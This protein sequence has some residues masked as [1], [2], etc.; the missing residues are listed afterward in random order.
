MKTSSPLH[1]SRL[2]GILD[3]T[4]VDT[5]GDAWERI[6]AA[7]LAGGVDLV[8]LRA[9]QSDANERRELL[10]RILP[11][12]AGRSTPLIINDD[13]ELAL[14]HPGLGLHVGQD[15]VPIAEAR[16]ALGPDRLLGLS[17]HTPDQA[18]EA[19]GNAGLLSYFAVGPVFATPTKPEATPVGLALVSHVS[20]LRPPLPWF[21]IG[22]IKL[23]NWNEVQAAGGRRAVVVSE[24]LQSP[25][26]AGHVRA[27]KAV[28]DF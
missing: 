25:D 19:I 28:I 13:L 9:K 5:R 2:Y 23:H 15:D 21:C 3:T 10:E 12:F 6:C 20:S 8:Q 1:S 4:C 11:L 26:P 17:T 24:I 7:I 22:G 27:L 18:A 16:A 14:S